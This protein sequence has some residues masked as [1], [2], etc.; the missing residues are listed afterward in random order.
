[1]KNITRALTTAV[2]LGTVT[3]GVQA[4]GVY[5][6][7]IEPDATLQLREL[8]RQLDPIEVETTRAGLGP[9][10]LVLGIASFDLALMGVYWGVYVPNYGNQKAAFNTNIH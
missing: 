1:M 2:L 6:G 10:A 9:L 5:S 3:T 7:A 4:A 8:P